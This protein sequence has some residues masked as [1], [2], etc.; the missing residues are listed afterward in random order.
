[1]SWSNW[2]ELTTGGVN[3]EVPATCGVFWIARKTTTAGY[4]VGSSTMVL[5][6]V[7]SD[8]QRGLRAV[9]NELIAKR[10]GSL[11]REREEGGGLRFCFQGNLGDKATALHDQLLAD[12]VKDHGEP[13]RCNRPS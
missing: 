1:M 2:F 12:F 11:E 9:L 10:P 7:A 5:L 8:R 6:G 4:A 3:N 13:P